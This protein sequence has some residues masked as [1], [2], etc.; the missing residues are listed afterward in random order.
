M[1]ARVTNWQ[2]L[3]IHGRHAVITR[4][5]YELEEYA[6]IDAHAAGTLE[7]CIIEFCGSNLLKARELAARS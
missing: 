2:L 4:L 7:A 3:S 5:R 6:V 1:S